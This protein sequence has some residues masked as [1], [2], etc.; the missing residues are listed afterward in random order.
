MPPRSR[1]TLVHRLPSPRIVLVLLAAGLVLGGCGQQAGT[2]ALPSPSDASQVATLP[3]DAVPT[4]AAPTDVLPSD[5][6]PTDV[7]P[8]D[9]GVLPSGTGGG[10]AGGDQ[11]RTVALNMSVRVVNLFIPKG[12]QQGSAVEVWVGSPQYGGKK[13][14]TVPYGQVS[15]FF[16]PEVTDSLGQGQTDSHPDYT[17][18]FYAAGTS[19]TSQELIDQGE[20][21][22]PG[23]K[24]TMVIAPGEPS[25]DGASLQ[26]FADDLGSDPAGGGFHTLSVPAPPSGSAVLLLGALALAHRGA[27]PTSPDSLT[28]S[29]VDG[30]CIQY[31][32][33]DTGK[34]HDPK[35]DTTD[36]V[37][38]TE[39]LAYVVQPGTQ[40][41]V[42]VVKDQQSVT[43]A[44]SSAPI[45]GPSD[46]KLA[47]GQRAYGFVYG[48]DL[49][50]AKLLV[51]PN[52]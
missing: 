4:D 47:A 45:V 14:Q 52:G 48:S 33:S 10:S 1:V 18:S 15:Q 8:S 9:D 41:R 16:A 39:S 49:K 38:G 25:S 36:L 11:N 17:L 34:V 20:N 30:K 3:T 40:I 27:D 7:L 37:G 22:S 13:L 6:V 19:A 46:P 2:A 26:V 43:Q 50:T 28:P 31:I 29:T 5:A 24:L 44:C 35:S 51:V 42:N 23:Q 12:S 32:E 21:A